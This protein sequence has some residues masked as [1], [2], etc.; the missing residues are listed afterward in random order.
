MASQPI[1][2]DNLVFLVINSF[3]LSF[4][5]LDL[6]FRTDFGTC[7]FSKR[8]SQATFPTIDPLVISNSG[9]ESH[10]H[11]I[12]IPIFI[13]SVNLSVST[14]GPVSVVQFSHLCFSCLR[15]SCHIFKYFFYFFITDV[16]YTFSCSFLKCFS[17]AFTLYENYSS[18]PEKYKTGETPDVHPPAFRLF[19]ASF[20]TLSTTSFACS[21][22]ASLRFLQ[23]V[24]PVSLHLLSLLFS[25]FLFLYCSLLFL[26]FYSSCPTK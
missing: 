23:R 8:V 9:S 24:P 5:G 20:A 14:P 12:I 3:S 1:Y 19:S 4:S 22:Q 18:T 2:W 13:R 17:G 10:K 7:I 11:L 6:A 16:F 21:L 25:G 15:V 26:H